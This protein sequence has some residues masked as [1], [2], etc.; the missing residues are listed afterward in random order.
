MWYSV[1]GRSVG[2]AVACREVLEWP[3]T[4]RGAPSPGG[5]GIEVRNFPQFS[6]ISQFSA[7]FPQFFAIGFDPPPPPDRNSPPPPCPSP[8][9]SQCWSR[10]T[11]HGHGEGNRP[12][13]R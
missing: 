10:Q 6:A 8:W 9:T 1:E 4:I 13:I 5:G 7:I 12:G 11:P 3:H 2:Q